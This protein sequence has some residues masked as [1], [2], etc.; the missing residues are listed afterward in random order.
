MRNLKSIITI[1]AISLATTFST[2]ATEKESSKITKKLRTEL[3]SMLGDKIKMDIK[4]DTT[5][6]IS[7]MINNKNEVIVLSVDSENKEFSSF[8]KSKLNYKKINVKGIQKG[9]I[10]K[11][12]VKI[13]AG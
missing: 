1:I 7:F 12:P 11:L 3:V 5:A 6:E 8:A 9:E 13:N 2:A 10:Y 4:K